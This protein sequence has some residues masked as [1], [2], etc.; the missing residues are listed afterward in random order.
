MRI[1]RRAVGL[2]LVSG[3]LLLAS[4]VPSPSMAAGGVANSAIVHTDAGW[5]RGTSEQGY[6]LYQGIP[7][8][9]PPVGD[10]RWRSPLPAAAWDG[11]R[12]AAEPGNRCP[13]AASVVGDPASDTEDCLYLNVTV[14]RAARHAPVLVWLH[15]G[16]L[17][18]GAG[19]DYDAHRLAM[20]GDLVVVTVNYRL[21]NLGFFDYP[22]L[23]NGGAF[24][25][26]DQQ[27][28][29]RWVQRNAAAFGGDPGNVTLA[30]ESA[31][32]HSVCTHLASPGSA[33]LFQRAIEQSTPCTAELPADAPFRPLLDVPHY[34]PPEWHDGH[35]Q[36]VATQVG[37]TDPAT[38]LSC[39]R[40]APVPALRAADPLPLP[41]YGNTVLPENPHDVFAAGRFNQ[42]PILTGVTRDEGTLFGPMLFPG[43]TPDQY[44]STVDARFGLSGPAVAARYPL[45][46][47]GGSAVQAMAAIVTDLDWAWP[48]H[49]TENLF[50]ARVATYAYEFLD[51]TAPKIPEFPSG[52][53]PLAS[54]GADL[55]YLFAFSDLTKEQ[56]AL[57]DQ[58]IDYWSTFAATGD[59]NR[60]GL[61]AWQ[62]VDPTAATPYVQGLDL[63]SGGVGPFDRTTAHNF[64][65]WHTLAES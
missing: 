21:G 35:G 62:P 41:G 37:C 22:G 58:M 34:V 29:L 51:R 33:G 18:T 48:Q 11:V 4:V 7:Y 10:L 6:R 56:R 49:K 50:A 9:A 40:A 1:S 54:H 46:E 53:E 14:P 5:V 60:R 12:D 15:G 25:I 36:A 32:A 52:V 47:H 65:F 61:P 63:G 8:A 39:L 43:L 2:A 16:S 57:G 30:G 26:E 23:E 42:V 55:S 20:R 64:D 45:S 19:S 31:G 3:G 59:P 44:A 17:M 38:A 27:A 13:Q 24:G 28:A